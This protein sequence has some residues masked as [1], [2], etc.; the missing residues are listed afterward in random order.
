MSSSILRIFPPNR[1]PLFFLSIAC[2][3]IYTKYRW[4]VRKTKNFSKYKGSLEQTFFSNPLQNKTKFS[5]GR[6]G[7]RVNECDFGGGRPPRN[8]R[9]LP[10]FR[11]QKL[12]VQP[13]YIMGSVLA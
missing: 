6:N 8:Q 2:C 11:I 10:C 9:S 5:S 13:Q 4:G 3:A 12:P 1:L 7:C